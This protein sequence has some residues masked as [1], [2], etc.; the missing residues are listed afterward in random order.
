[1]VSSV[2]LGIQMRPHRASEVRIAGSIPFRLNFLGA[3]TKVIAPPDLFCSA[4]ARLGRHFLAP[5]GPGDPAPLPT[6]IGHGAAVTDV[7]TP[8]LLDIS[9]EALPSSAADLGVPLQ[10]IMTGELLRHDDRGAA[11]GAA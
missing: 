3:H 2:Y 11:T 8:R 9:T 10:V 1:M 4:R 7:V 5:R 6:L